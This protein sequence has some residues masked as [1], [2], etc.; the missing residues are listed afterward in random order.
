MSGVVDP[1]Q[2]FSVVLSL[3]IRFWFYCKY[4]DLRW[5]E[6]VQLN[7]ISNLTIGAY[8]FDRNIDTIRSVYCIFFQ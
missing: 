4:D 8:D 2:N 6:R 3:K 5:N 1:Q 7:E